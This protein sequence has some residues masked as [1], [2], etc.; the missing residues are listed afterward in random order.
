MP[1]LA[2][3]VTTPSPTAKLG[4][5]S[6]ATTSIEAVSTAPLNALAPT[7]GSEIVT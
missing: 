3:V 2:A 7:P 4:A 5:S 6:T 1:V